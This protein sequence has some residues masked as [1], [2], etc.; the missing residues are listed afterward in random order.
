MQIFQYV[1]M[2][3]GTYWLL[4]EEGKKVYFSN[5]ETFE[6]A[7]KKCNI[8]IE[9]TQSTKDNTKNNTENNTNESNTTNNNIYV[10]NN[11]TGSTT[12]STTNDNSSNTSSNW[13]NWTTYIGVPSEFKIMYN[14]K[15]CVKKPWSN[16]YICC[17]TDPAQT[18]NIASSIG[19]KYYI[20]S[21]LLTNEKY[22]TNNLEGFKYTF[23]NVDNITFKIVV[24][25]LYDAD[26]NTIINQ[27][28]TIFETSYSVEDL[29]KNYT[30]GYGEDGFVEL[31]NI[32]TIW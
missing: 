30:H 12:S 8:S 23:N 3:N 2:K 24:P 26:T 21:T 31:P 17:L 5:L 27:N 14:N 22:L 7:L 28:V 4:D 11:N 6:S 19:A 15:Y 25:Y 1:L 9:D 16:Y 20:N 32:P 18:N 10:E 13:K 29:Y